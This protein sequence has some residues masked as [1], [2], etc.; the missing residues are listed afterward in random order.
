MGTFTPSCLP[1][2]LL[3]W[4]FTHRGWNTWNALT[5]T[6][7]NQNA[8]TSNSKMSN[9][10]HQNLTE[11][12]PTVIHKEPADRWEPQR[13]TRGSSEE[14]IRQWP[15][16]NNAKIIW[17]K[18]AA[19]NHIWCQERNLRNT[20]GLT[21]VQCWVWTRGR[22]RCQE[23]EI[24]GLS[25]SAAGGHGYFLI[26]EEI[27]PGKPLAA[28]WSLLLSGG[29]QPMG[30]EETETKQKTLVVNRV[31]VGEA[32]DR[33]QF[34]VTSVIYDSLYPHI[35]YLKRK[36]DALSSGAGPLWQGPW[37]WDGAGATVTLGRDGDSTGVLEW[38]HCCHIQPLPVGKW[39]SSQTCVLL[40]RR[41]NRG[42]CEDR[43]EH[44]GNGAVQR[45][46]L[47]T[48]LWDLPTWASNKSCCLDS[49]LGMS[50]FCFS[51]SSQCCKNFANLKSGRAK[52]VLLYF[53]YLFPAP[54]WQNCALYCYKRT[55]GQNY[56]NRE[57]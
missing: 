4:D 8:E 14:M 34:R 39:T 35:F 38:G 25:V 31:E 9:E 50:F 11:G 5:R 36:A 6:E 44:G 57:L 18:S 54:C 29:T 45:V 48:A 24:R 1:L 56:F 47:N 10:W 51:E 19:E 40:W 20:A 7:R 42:G 22:A 27:L 12:K 52:P 26:R 32:W 49:G 37:P 17:I 15:G 23:G 46:H 28:G 55:L 3:D 43:F 21:A 2:Q 13:K 16:T 33:I 41:E 30:V 53:S